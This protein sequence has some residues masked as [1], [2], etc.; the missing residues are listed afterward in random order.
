VDPAPLDSGIGVYFTKMTWGGVPMA[1]L[2]DR[3]WKSGPDSVL[4]KNPQ[5]ESNCG[6]DGSAARQSVR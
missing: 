6:I 4:P 5:C 3:K 1:I 2:E